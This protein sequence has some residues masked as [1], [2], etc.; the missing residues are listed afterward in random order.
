MKIYFL[1]LFIA[2]CLLQPVGL[3]SSTPRKKKSTSASRKKLPYKAQVPG[4]DPTLGDNVDGDDLT[5]RRAA[6][7]ALGSFAGSVVVVDPSNGRI[8]SMVNQRLALK[9]GFVPC[10]TVK[11]VTAL[12]ALTEGVVSKNT[13]IYTSRYVTYNLT[14]ALARSNNQYFNILGTRL[15]F[16][17]VHHYAEML[18]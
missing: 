12:A 2:C 18:G 11:L 10:S 9:T 15:G 16:D 6:V 3:A 7:A 17:R 13:T 5:I 1:F 8:L 14:Q 4:V